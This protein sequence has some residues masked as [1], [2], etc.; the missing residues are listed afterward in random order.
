[1]RC[2]IC[3]RKLDGPG[4]PYTRKFDKRFYVKTAICP[5]CATSHRNLLRFIV[6]A[7]CLALAAVVLIAFCM[8]RAGI[9]VESITAK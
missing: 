3:G 7:I 9:N 8:T 1:M 5:D 4:V 2:D 6:L